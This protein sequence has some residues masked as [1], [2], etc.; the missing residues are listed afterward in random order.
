MT[1]SPLTKVTNK[2]GM[3]VMTKE[4]SSV[5]PCFSGILR[6]VAAILLIAGWFIIVTADAAVEGKIIAVYCDAAMSTNPPPGWKFQWNAAG[7]IDNPAGFADL[8]CIVSSAGKRKFGSVTYGIPDTNGNAR[9]DRPSH[10]GFGDTF[11]AKDADGTIR[12]SIASYTLQ[13]DSSGEI[14]VNNGNLSCRSF[15]DT[16]MSIYLNNELKSSHALKEDAPPLLFQ[17]KMGRLKKGDTIRVVIG[18]G[19]K[20]RKGGGRMRYTIE[21]FPAGEKPAAPVNILRPPINEPSPQYGP[22]GRYTNYLAKHQAQCDAV[23]SNNSELVLIGDSITARW[24]ME[25]L[26]TKYGKYRPV[27]LGIGGDWIQ[28]VLWRLL[29]GV[30]DKVKIKVIVLLIGT[31]NISNSFTPEEVA[32]GIKELLKTIHEKSP[33]SKILLMGIF[34]AG[35]SIRDPKCVKRLEANEKLAKLADNKMVFFLDI[36]DK[37]VEPDG[38]ISAKV[39]PDKL[40][41]A[42]PGFERW[43]EA[44][45]PT[46]DKLLEA[47]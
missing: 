36:G 17:E 45:G 3:K 4:R 44:M 7:S 15:D 25:L 43:L 19:E 11:A 12:Y 40:H 10:G 5:M 41:V 47:Q 1:G 13:E 34:P 32:G 24:P 26:Q 20:E 46:L 30:L 8:V 39:M 23:L 9:T 14:W 21:E 28:N 27:N 37:L 35:D 22:D 38:T 18:P 29:N 31:N 42:M 6:S 33:G 16:R 2:K